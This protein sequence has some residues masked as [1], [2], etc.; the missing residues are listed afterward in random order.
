ML[1]SGLGWEADITDPL[2]RRRDLPVIEIPN[3][4]RSV[5]AVLLPQCCRSRAIRIV[6]NDKQLPALA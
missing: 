4:L 5:R 3:R 2:G 1:M 6:D